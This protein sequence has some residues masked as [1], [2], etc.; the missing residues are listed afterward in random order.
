MGQSSDD[1]A[2]PAF[3]DAWRKPLRPDFLA[4]VALLGNSP[5]IR[6]LIARVEQVAEG[7]AAVLVT[8]ERGTG[9][10]SVARHLHESSARV[11]RPLVELD[12]AAIPES[13]MEAALF[14]HEVGAFAGRRLGVF[15]QAAGGTLALRNPHV[16]TPPSQASVHA[17][18]QEGRYRVL[19]TDVV[20]Q[21]DVRMATITTVDLRAM[22][23]AGACSQEL[24]RRLATVTIEVPPLR[25]RGDDVLA[26]AQVM[27][28]RLCHALDRADV[29]LTD[30]V[31]ARL[32]RYWWPANVRELYDAVQRG[33]VTSRDGR[34][35][36]LELPLS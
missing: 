11:T 15:A 26:I 27:I 19:G 13:L 34:T 12:C 8:G 14:G 23:E 16:L 29:A 25:D 10:A 2:R 30:D 33:L 36:N 3:M 20:E 18:L 5:A 24:Y 22:A 28:A 35:L 32:V 7:D 1:A 21:L 6:S 4:S 17:A 9:K 31:A